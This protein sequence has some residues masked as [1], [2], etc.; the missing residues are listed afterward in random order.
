M[1]IVGIREVSAFYA[2][3]RDDNGQELELEI[4]A[5]GFAGLRDLMERQP[6]VDERQ[7]QNAV[8]S[9]FFDELT[10]AGLET[11]DIG[12]G[13]PEQPEPLDEMP[14]DLRAKLSMVGVG[15]DSDPDPGEVFQDASQDEGGEQ[16]G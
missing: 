13:R 6:S 2:V 3:V 15:V 7:H 14:D 1:R 4:S 12:G 11:P 9:N 10:G 16:I 5:A 8:A